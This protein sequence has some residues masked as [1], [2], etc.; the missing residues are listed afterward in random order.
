MKCHKKIK[1]E[2]KNTWITMTQKWDMLQ[3]QQIR[4]KSKEDS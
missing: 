4:N 2:V 3:I 1:K